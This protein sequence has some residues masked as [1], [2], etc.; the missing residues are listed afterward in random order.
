MQSNKMNEKGAHKAPLD[1]IDNCIDRAG[2]HA[3]PAIGTIFGDHVNLFRFNYR[4]NWA[5]LDTGPAGYAFFSYFHNETP[6]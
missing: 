1:S 6:P 3:R 5:G 2:I 4:A